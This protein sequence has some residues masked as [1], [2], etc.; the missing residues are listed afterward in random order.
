MALKQS[1]QRKVQVI[2][3]D[4]EVLVKESGHR[5]QTAFSLELLQVKQE[6]RDASAAS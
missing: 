3:T 1:C 2:R 5:G 6:Q 4:G